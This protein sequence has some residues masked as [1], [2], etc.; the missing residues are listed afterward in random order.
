MK[1]EKVTLIEFDTSKERQRILRGFEGELRTRLLELLEQFER[2]EF[3]AL[4]RERANW[5]RDFAECVHPVINDTL[6]ALAERR[7]GLQH[8]PEGPGQGLSEHARQLLELQGQPLGKEGLD[9]PKFKQLP[10]DLS[11]F[12]NPND[13]QQ[14][15]GYALHVLLSMTHGLLQARALLEAHAAGQPQV[16]Q[17]L[18]DTQA[19]A[20][21][22]Q[23]V[24][25][26]LES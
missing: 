8:W 20:K 9:Y 25:S 10:A 14:H 5:D 1:I 17:Y 13:V 11:A 6:S 7:V 12:Q 21:S 3:E 18:A 15:H 23:V 16:Q 24:L 2:G 19:L 4:A 26:Q 22:A